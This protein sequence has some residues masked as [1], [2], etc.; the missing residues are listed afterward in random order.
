MYMYCRMYIVLTSCG[1]AGS[2]GEGV[3]EDVRRDIQCKMKCT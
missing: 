1:C 2:N 3:M